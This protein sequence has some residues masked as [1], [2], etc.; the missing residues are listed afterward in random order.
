MNKTE[1]KVPYYARLYF[2]FQA[3]VE[4]PHTIIQIKLSEE[5]YRSAENNI[6]SPLTDPLLDLPH[7][8]KR[9]MLLKEN[10]GK[11]SFG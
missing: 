9:H 3:P 4:Q 5:F 1:L 7:V 2:T 11:V 6:F 8:W 10:I